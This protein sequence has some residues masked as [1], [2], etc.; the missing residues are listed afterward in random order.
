MFQD[1]GTLYGGKIIKEGSVVYAERWLEFLQIQWEIP[2]R[3]QGCF[4]T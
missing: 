3:K 2:I 1:L 4:T